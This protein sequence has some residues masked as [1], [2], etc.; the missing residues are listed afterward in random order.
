MHL[1]LLDFAT[2]FNGFYY[3]QNLK[4]NRANA[5]QKIIKVRHVYSIIMSLGFEVV[6]MMQKNYVSLSNSWSAAI[7]VPNIDLVC[8]IEETL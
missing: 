1:S 5:Q 7:L 4:E 8:C 6:V 2:S 3:Y